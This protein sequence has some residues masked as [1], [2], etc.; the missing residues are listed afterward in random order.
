MIGHA[1]CQIKHSQKSLWTMQSLLLPYW[2]KVLLIKIIVFLLRLRICKKYWELLSLPP[3]L[4]K[5]F[6]EQWRREI[7]T[8]DLFC[9]DMIFGLTKCQISSEAHINLLSYPN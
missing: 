9:H 2:L 7:S 1:L 6:T 4:A 5:I 8:K 3:H